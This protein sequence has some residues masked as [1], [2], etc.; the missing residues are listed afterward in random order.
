MTRRFSWSFA[1][2]VVLHLAILALLILVSPMTSYRLNTTVPNTKPVV[3]AA[4][5]DDAQ[6]AAQVQNIQAR[7]A[8]QQALEQQRLQ[9]LQAQAD[10]AR[11]AKT[12]E[13]QRLAALKRTA[14]QQAQT[15][16]Q[17]LAQ[18]KAQQ[19]QQAQALAAL[20]K[21]QQEAQAK[22][23]ALKKQQE[24]QAKSAAAAKKQ[25]ELEAAKRRAELAA[26]QAALQQQLTQ[27][28]LANEQQE[29]LQAQQR[30]GVIDQYRARI[31]MAIGNQW[32]IPEGADPTISVV[33]T[34]DL[35]VEG[36]VSNVRLVRASGNAALDRAAETAIYKASPLPV[37][38]DP[39]TFAPFRHFVLKMTP[40]DIAH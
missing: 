22:V 10:A 20:Q 35:T 18:L 30:Q 34:I 9:A 1:L 40:Q 32:L 38:K 23:L 27:Q 33:F 15:E 6:V 36:V 3:H 7:E 17:R 25:Q 4:V 13:E 2:S 12:A 24:E 31:L 11:Q 16:Q 14:A 5:V 26:Q 28:Q 29:L 21:Q 19:Q 37:P 39:A 8:R